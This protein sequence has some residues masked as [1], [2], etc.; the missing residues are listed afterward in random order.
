MYREREKERETDSQTDRDRQT[1][2]GRQTPHGRTHAHTFDLGTAVTP[3]VS[4]VLSFRPPTKT[5]TTPVK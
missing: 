2:I 4:D 3:A 5:T 1:E